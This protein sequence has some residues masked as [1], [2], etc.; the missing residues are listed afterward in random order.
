[1]TTE[2]V[3]YKTTKDSIKLAFK[4]LEVAQREQRRLMKEGDYQQKSQAQSH[5]IVNRYELRHYYIA[6][7]QFRKANSTYS[8]YLADVKEGTII[9]QDY[10]DRIITKNAS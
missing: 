3:S 2:E 8:K 5:H 10:I 6:Y 9:D 4:K 1:M 7:H